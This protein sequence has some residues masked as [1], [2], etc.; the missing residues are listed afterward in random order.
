MLTKSKY[1]VPA[2]GTKHFRD[3]NTEKNNIGD[4]MI[5]LIK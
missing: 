2:Y 5:Y 3:E 1:S 4:V